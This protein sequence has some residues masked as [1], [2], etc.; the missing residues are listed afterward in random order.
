MS[1]ASMWGQCW[2]VSMIWSGEYSMVAGQILVLTEILVRTSTCPVME[3]SY[4]SN[5]MLCYMHSRGT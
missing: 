3:G 4:G 2:K 1:W 5:W